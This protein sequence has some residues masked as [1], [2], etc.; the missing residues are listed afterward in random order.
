MT[1]DAAFEAI[2]KA[3]RQADS[4]NATGA[5]NTL[6][7]YLATDPHNTKPRLELAK[8]SIYNLKDLRYGLMQLDIIMDLEPENT[9]AM[10]A[11]VT[12]MSEDKKYTEKTSEIFDKL[13]VLEPTADVYN[14]YAKFLRRQTGDFRKAGEYYE[15]ALAL[16]PNDVDIHQNYAVLLLN[17]LHDYPKAKE[18]LGWNPTKTSFEELVRI[19]VDHDMK[20]VAKESA[21]ERIINLAEYLEKGV[22][23]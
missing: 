10:K 6:E 9:D 16:K 18:E 2:S 23:K 5:V 7:A 15:K 11:A 8:I 20:K 13:L 12:V 3:R 1:S 21:V 22:V 4:N 17:D 19:M 14:L